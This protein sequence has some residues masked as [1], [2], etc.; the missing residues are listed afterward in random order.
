MRGRVAV[1]GEMRGER[2]NVVQGLSP[3]IDYRLGVG[4]DVDLRRRVRDDSVAGIGAVIVS[5]IFT[6]VVLID[7]ELTGST[8]IGVVL[9]STA[10]NSTAVISTEFITSTVTDH[11]K[12]QLHSLWL[13]W[14]LAVSA[15]LLALMARSTASVPGFR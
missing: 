3:G 14:R 7:N 6:S 4:Q 11:G 12:S 1:L 10:P 8:P 15:A 9:I 13:R 2:G 5:I